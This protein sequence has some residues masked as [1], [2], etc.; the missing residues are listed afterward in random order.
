MSLHEKVT[1]VNADNPNQAREV[2]GF[3]TMLVAD[4]KYIAWPCLTAAEEIEKRNKMWTFL[5]SEIAICDL[6]SRAARTS[7]MISLHV[8]RKEAYRRVLVYLEEKK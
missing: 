8:G 2:C 7:E 6:L 4:K 5:E 3:C 1:I